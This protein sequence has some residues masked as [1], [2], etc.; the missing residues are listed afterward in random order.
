[1]CAQL[2]AMATDEE[3]FHFGLVEIVASLV[4]VPNCG[5]GLVMTR[6]QLDAM[7]AR[8]AA[9]V[10]GITAREVGHRRGLRAPQPV[11]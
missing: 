11:H 5:A 1:M 10:D 8:V 2:R 9:A 6:T 4:A 7:A 3:R